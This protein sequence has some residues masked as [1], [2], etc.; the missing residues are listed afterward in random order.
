M[1]LESQKLL[2]AMDLST[3]EMMRDDK[4]FEEDQLARAAIE[5]EERQKA[6]APKLYLNED[7]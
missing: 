6:M 3:Q 5:R 2:P 1:D 4:I 7:G